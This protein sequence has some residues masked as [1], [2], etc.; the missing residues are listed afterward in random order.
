M[1]QFASACKGCEREGERSENLFLTR[2]DCA[3]SMLKVNEGR[4]GSDC[5]AEHGTWETENRL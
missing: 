3:H 1:C 5:R 2:E 4:T